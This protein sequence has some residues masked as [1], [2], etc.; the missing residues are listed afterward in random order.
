MEHSFY[1][2]ELR[3]QL[4][5]DREI[6]RETLSEGTC[7]GDGPRGRAAK[8]VPELV[9]WRRGYSHLHQE[10]EEELTTPDIAWL[11]K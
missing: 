4:K 1:L 10:I 11:D 2:E 8:S 5:I 6:S 9:F 3:L 7:W